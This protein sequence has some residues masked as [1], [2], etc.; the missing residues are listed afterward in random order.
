M[1][2]QKILKILLCIRNNN[3]RNN[4]ETFPLLMI[5]IIL[6]MLLNNKFKSKEEYSYFSFGYPVLSTFYFQ[7]LIKK[8]SAY[9][10]PIFINCYNN[11]YLE[12]LYYIFKLFLTRN[13]N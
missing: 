9:L 1:I 12:T 13:K 6:G 3:I 11:N 7:T 4:K 10:F 5:Y 2:S 8:N